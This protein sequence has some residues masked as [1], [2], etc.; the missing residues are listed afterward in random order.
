MDGW[1]W[2][3]GEQETLTQQLNLDPTCSKGR[4]SIGNDLTPLTV[5]VFL[6]ARL[7]DLIRQARKLD[8]QLATDLESEFTAIKNR[9][10]FGLVFEPHLPEAVELPNHPLRRGIKVR[11][12]PPRGDLSQPDK[13]I[14]IIESIQSTSS[15]KVANLVEM[16]V[17]EP[18]LLAAPVEDLVVIAEFRD[19]IYPGL[20]ETGRVERG[21]EKPYH[22][23]INSENYHALEMLTYTH[24]HSIDVVYIDPPYN[25]GARDWKYNNDYVEADDDYRHSK[26]LAMMERRLKIAREL[27]NPKN[28]VLI[29]TIDEKE[30]LRLGLLLE[31]T[32]PE[33]DIQMVSSVISPSG[34]SRSSRF[35]RAD[36]YLFFV[37]I[38]T[39][40]VTPW[41]TDMLRETSSNSGRAV[42]WNGLIRNG[43]GSNRS[44]IPSMFYPIHFNLADSSFHSVGEPLPPHFPREDY[45]PPTGTVALFPV[46][47][48]GSEMMWRLS[49]PT[50]REYLRSGYARFGRPNSDGTR[51]PMYLQRGM[52]AKLSSGEI[53]VKGQK[54]DGSL[55][56]EY[57]DGRGTFAPLTVWNR[58]SHSAAEHGS[59]VLKRI[60][61]GRKFPFPKSLYAVEDT[62]RFF[63][64]KKSDAIILDFFSGSGTTAHAVMRLNKQDGG[65][66]QCIS[67]TNNEVG[68]A[69]QKRLRKMGLRP[70]DPE[71]EALGICDFIT[72]PRITA[73]ISG[74]TPDGIPIKGDY[75]F[76]DKFP[77]RDGFS[78]NA[79]FF[80][81]TYESPYSVRHQRSFARI[82]PLLWLRAGAR[83]RIITELG[84]R[85]WE[86]AETHAVIEDLD[87][88]EAFLQATRNSEDL[89]I[90]YVITDDDSA[91]QMLIRDLPKSITPVQ[92]YESYLQNFEINTG[93]GL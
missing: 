58:V 45:T 46:D 5:G 53:I 91:F 85:G 71:W 54:P 19:R 75:K 72:M 42:R 10:T 68:S 61:P 9:R 26:W 70:G 36:E 7:D 30:F 86:V 92:L 39:A 14:W 20:V 56:L 60:I 47:R 35:G 73:A 29:V 50:L 55:D 40:G 4:Q 51:P 21:G 83:G 34:S 11:K 78:E 31:Q 43:A 28:S 63:V 16:G 80:T 90:V 18:E 41:T 8:P 33:A 82:G 15:G 84:D 74:T 62:I 1:N 76:T 2:I 32:F 89:R 67:I 69:E 65:T 59:G 27:M 81:L 6:V 93:R 12:L 57:A 17:Q 13:R 87:D 37:F 66:R 24:R 64:S 38:G 88:A 44:R 22:T 52:I 25:T 49:P 79:A 48:S 23:V 77:M 3:Y